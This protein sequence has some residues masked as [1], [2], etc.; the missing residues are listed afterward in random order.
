MKYCNSCGTPVQDGVKFC[1]KCGK[2]IS[3]P[4]Q[5]ANQQKIGQQQGKPMDNGYQQPGMNVGVCPKTWMLEAILVTILCCLPFGIV[6][7][8]NAS[9]VKSQFNIGNI[10]GA[11]QASKNAGK[12]VKIG[13]II[14]LVGNIIGTIA[15]MGTA[16]AA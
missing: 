14:G 5:N 6:G 9:K 8:V 13:F 11:E 10:G 4:A 3:S 1:P 12:W 15:Y 7:I 2:P 16:M